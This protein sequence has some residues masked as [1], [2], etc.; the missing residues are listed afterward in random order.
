MGGTHNRAS[1]HGLQTR[2]CLALGRILSSFSRASR[3]PETPGQGWGR[4]QA[5]ALSEPPASA[6]SAGRVESSGRVKAEALVALGLLWIAC[7][8]SQFLQFQVLSSSFIQTRL[9]V[10]ALAGSPATPGIRGTEEVP[11]LGLDSPG[12]GSLCSTLPGHLPCPSP[13]GAALPGGRPVAARA[14]KAAA[15]RAQLFETH[16]LSP[17]LL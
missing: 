11:R 17:E 12:P 9:R 2:V 14:G 5:R 10:L 4:A 8:F 1:Q 3:Y 13:R 7:C 6:G 16:L 15:G